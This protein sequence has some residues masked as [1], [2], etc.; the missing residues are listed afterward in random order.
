MATTNF[1]LDCRAIGK[2]QLAP[3]KISINKK[4]RTALIHLDVYILPSQW[5]RKSKRI[6]EHKNKVNLNAYIYHRKVDVDNIILSMYGVEACKNMT[7]Q[8]IKEYVLAKLK[9][10][11]S[12]DLFAERFLR[13]ANSKSE[14]TKRIYLYTYNRLQ[15]FI[16]DK[17]NSLRFEDITKE[18]L[19]EFENFLAKT[20]T[21][22]SRNISLRN[23]RAVFNEAIDNGITSF[24]PFRRFPIT[25][26]AT[27]KRSLSLLQLATLFNTKCELQEYL[28]IFKLVFYLI[29]INIIDLYNLTSITDEGRIEY[30][31]SKTNKFYSIKVESEAM[32]IINKYRGE[33][34]LLSI[35]DRCSNHRNY[36]H[37]INE[38]LQHIGPYT[39]KGRGGKRHYSPLF[40]NITTYW[41]RHTWATI[42][43]ELDIPKETIA[44]ALGHSI[45]NPTTSIYIDF[46]I[47]K[48]DEANRTIIDCVN[49]AQFV[50][51]ISSFID[52]MSNSEFGHIAK[53]SDCKND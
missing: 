3:L 18:W 6:I 38:A 47:K 45:G 26:V 42:A 35:K 24:Y 29:G 12:Q 11:N 14:S 19:T 25:P 21:K 43:A 32:T 39:K 50:L 16:G 44:A 20:A 2:N 41:A 53:L 15:A 10:D 7:A 23:I 22:N 8:Q 40:P 31:R 13:F 52:K 4:G 36:I 48:I 49:C 17:L 5:D 27:P 28:D 33:N 9:L 37:R 1:Y 30:Y 51:F 34:N 46:N